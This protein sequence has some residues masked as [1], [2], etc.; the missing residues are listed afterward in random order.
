MQS[1]KATIL[2]LLIFPA[3][4]LAI[5]VPSSQS[6]DLVTHRMQDIKDTYLEGSK[7]N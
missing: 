6:Q 5:H 7:Q 1:S 4:F 3:I 2:L